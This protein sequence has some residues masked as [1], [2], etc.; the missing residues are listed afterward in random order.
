MLKTK[1]ISLVCSVSEEQLVA[2]PRLLKFSKRLDEVDPL[3]PSRKYDDGD[4]FEV[5]EE[6]LRNQSLDQFLT[7]MTEQG[8]KFVI[9]WYDRKETEVWNPKKKRKEMRIYHNLAFIFA[10]EEDAKCN[11]HFAPVRPVIRAE[12]QKFFADY[13]FDVRRFDDHPYR[14]N[15]GD[16][17]DDC[18]RWDISLNNF[19]AI[20]PGKVNEQL[21]FR[22]GV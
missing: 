13:T 6:I 17:V 5:Y 19:R 21:A 8:Y 9:A 2:F 15:E 16:R 20:V 7:A 14:N 1:V 4:S 18:R 3:L 12:F 22:G 10:E 11:V